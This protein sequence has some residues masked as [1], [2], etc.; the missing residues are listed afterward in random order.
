MSRSAYARALVCV[1]V[2][3]RACYVINR[4]IK[5]IYCNF[6]YVS[7]FPH[8][9]NFSQFNFKFK[10]TCYIYFFFF[11]NCGFYFQ[12]SYNN[13]RKSLSNNCGIIICGVHRCTSISLNGVCVYHNM[14]KFRAIFILIKTTS[15]VSGCS[16]R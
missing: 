14:L 2:C 5:Y 9:S 12:F 10:L 15:Y 13:V 16:V 1:C 6:K 11:P 3:F 7:I 8:H 4:S